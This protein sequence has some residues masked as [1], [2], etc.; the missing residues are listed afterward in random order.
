MTLHRFWPFGLLALALASTGCNSNGRTNPPDT[1]VRVL[2]VVPS[3]PSLNYRREQITLTNAS[4]NLPFQGAA[5]SDF[6]YDEDTYNFSVSAIDP[7]ASVPTQIDVDGFSHKVVAG[8][9]YTFVF[10]ESGGVVE[11]AILEQPRVP[12]DKA[13]AQVQALNGD[14]QLPAVDV[15]LETSGSG[16][17]GATPWGTIGFRES[18]ASK[19][20][21]AG[22]YELTVT[23]AGNAANVLFTTQ[24]FTVDSTTSTT[25]VLSPDAGEGIA[26]FSVVLLNGAGAT[27][28]T[29]PSFPT[30][31]RALNGATDQA[32]RDVAFNS[33]FTPPLLSAA[34]FGTPTPYQPLVGGSTTHVD[35]TP[36]GNPG[37][38]EVSTD[39]IFTGAKTNTLFFTGDAGALR[40]VTQLDDHRRVTGQGKVT[41]YDAAPVATPVEVLFLL[42]GADPLTA[43]LSVSTF[44]NTGD[45]LPIAIAPEAYEIFLRKYDDAGAKTIVGGPFSLTVV[46]RGLYEVLFTNDANGT[47]VD[48]TLIGSSP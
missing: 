27:P 35:V 44:M 13:N 22:V 24:P 10:I 41:F 45:V 33:Q 6:V 31:V 9:L 38:L 23:E 3:R 29:D 37:V 39:I 43:P 14:E 20:V 7:A 26:P 25:L 2:N 19:E 8:T 1:F 28:L 48:L 11:H 42:P 36:A 30:Y 16:I 21:A 15:Y 17:A 4:T 32:P 12:S 46:E 5:T 40:L 47:T 34:A 18:I